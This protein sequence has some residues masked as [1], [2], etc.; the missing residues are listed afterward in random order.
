MRPFR[1]PRLAPALGRQSGLLVCAS[2][3]RQIPAVNLAVMNVRFPSC[4]VRR[5]IGCLAL[6]APEYRRSAEAVAAL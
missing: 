1:Q 2:L 6:L 4:P 3:T 5:A